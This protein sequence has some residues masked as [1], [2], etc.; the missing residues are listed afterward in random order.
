MSNLLG[1]V[2]L[3]ERERQNSQS[4]QSTTKLVGRRSSDFS[5]SS[6][7][8]SDFFLKLEAVEI[9]Y[10]SISLLGV[11]TLSLGANLKGH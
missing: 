6:A 3:T 11:L 7:Y 8:S 9:L 10:K 1:R 4:E 2:P 5:A